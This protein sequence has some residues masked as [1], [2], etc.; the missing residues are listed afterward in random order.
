MKS[1]FKIFFLWLGL[2]ILMMFF[3]IFGLM[4]G[5]MLFPG[6]LSADTSS[7]E[8]GAVGILFLISLMNTAVI[9]YFIRH[10]RAGGMHLVGIV[11]FMTYGIQYFMSQIETL[12]FREAVTLP[13][14]GVYLLL[15]SGAIQL[16]LF[17]M[18]AVWLTGRF[19]YKDTS[20]AGMSMPA[21]PVVLRIILLA[22]FVWPV[23]YFLAGYY[24]AWQF[25]EVRQFYSGSTE[26]HSFIFLMKENIVSGLWFFQ[27]LRG[28]LW[29]LIFLPAIYLLK[30]HLLKKSI[31]AGLMIAVLGG[32][33]LLL[34][35]PYMPETVRMAHLLETVPSNFL[36]GFLM[37]QV[38]GEIIPGKKNTGSNMSLS[39]PD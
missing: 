15:A 5:N 25:P 4:I 8:G 18:A 10:L 12:W 14:R 35:N 6:A 28:I 11:F 24:I 30:G 21:G 34:P 19:K 1:F 33:Q 36:W 27:V 9:L 7:S 17:S 23:I 29:I 37:V 38:L 22:L 3:W 39:T 16:F 26:I 31:L 32:S 13:V 20:P 2:S